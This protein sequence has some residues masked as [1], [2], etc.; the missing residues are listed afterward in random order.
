[1]SK[2]KIL[3]IDDDKLLSRT[4]K[5]G[6][7][8][9]GPYEVKIENNSKHAVNTTRDFRPDLILLDVIM[10][11]MDGGDVAS[12]IRED[13]ELKDTPIIFLTSIL[14]KGEAAAKDGIIGEESMM[15]KPVSLNELTTRIE[16]TI[17]SKK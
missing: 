11:G 4:I 12:A 13:S 10:P 6:L 9:S 16:K 8:Q 2:R 14:G 1:M 3:I 7:E 5:A 15:A 17:K